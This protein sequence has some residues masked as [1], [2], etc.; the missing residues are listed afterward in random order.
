M[1]E[2]VKRLAICLPI[3]PHSPPRPYFQDIVARMPNLTHLDL[4]MHVAMSEIEADVLELFRGLPKLQQVILPNYHFTTKVVEE[5]S[6]LP[7]LGTFQFEYGDEQGYG[8]PDDVQLFSPSLS[9]GAFPS[10]FDI[11]LTAKLADV[12]RFMNTSFA[13]TNIT[14]LYVD[15]PSLTP[16]SPSTIHDFLKTIADNCQLLKSLYLAI[17]NDFRSLASEPSSEEQVTFETLRP[18][19]NCANLVIFEMTHEFPLNLTLGDIDELASKWPSLESLVLNCEPPNLHHSSLGLDALLPFARHCQELRQLGLFLNASSAEIPPLHDTKPF[20]KLGKLSVGTSRIVE[21]GP[22][23]LFLSELC[24][25][26]CEIEYGVTWS[27]DFSN[28]ELG[29]EEN[30][31]LINEIST[32]CD[33]WNKVGELLPLLTQLRMEER[34][35]VKALRKEV[36]DLRIRVNL[37][38]D[39]EKLMKAE[40]HFVVL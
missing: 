33:K 13:P 3:F 6:K 29:E 11:S 17:L 38:M 20:R 4:R 15:S 21:A 35:K 24:P 31:G 8:S 14:S 2:N 23:A 10:L 19:L 37:L 22:I 9:Q 30:R 39:R 1:H 34:N 5:L 7:H 16:E 27:R 26:G 28:S 32:R 40:G 25:L 36:E 18:L 12:N